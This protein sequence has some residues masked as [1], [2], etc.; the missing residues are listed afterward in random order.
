MAD[1][2]REVY[3]P[4]QMTLGKVLYRDLAYFNGPL[5][6]HANARWFRMFGTSIETL[7]LINAAILA[8][9]TVVVYRIFVGASG[10]IT[11]TPA[12]TVLLGAFGFVRFT[13]VSYYNYIYIFT[14][15]D[16][17]AGALCDH[18]PAIRPPTPGRQP[19]GGLR[20]G[21]C[22]GL[23]ALTKA[24]AAVAAGVVAA[25]W[26]ALGRTLAATRRLDRADVGVFLA[27]AARGARP[28]R[29][30]ECPSRRGVALPLSTDTR[31]GSTSDIANNPGTRGSR[32]FDYASK[33]Y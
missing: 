7:A 12:C 8:A 18:D 23:V 29:R 27:G 26:M 13:Y 16:A 30:P 24:E 10:P 4:W 11:A 5:S 19:M 33:S 9:M 28:H 6:P 1:F 2:G 17:W 14:L 15:I 31:Q 3:I 22:F 21:A 20:R 25:V 32:T